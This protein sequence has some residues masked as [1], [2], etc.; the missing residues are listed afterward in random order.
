MNLK[1]MKIAYF[2]SVVNVWMAALPPDPHQGLCPWTPLGHAPRPHSYPP[3]LSDLPPPVSQCI[4]KI[5]VLHSKIP[6]D[7]YSVRYWPPMKW[8]LIVCDDNSHL[9]LGADH[10]TRPIF[11]KTSQLTTTTTTTTTT[12]LQPCS[13]LYRLTCVSWHPELITGG[14]CWS[15]VLLP[16][17]RCWQLLVHSALGRIC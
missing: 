8:H 5:P 9:S 6:V 7:H 2:H 13:P 11:T 17:C 14:F 10:V 15:K 1:T 3:T 16:T 12:I 4:I